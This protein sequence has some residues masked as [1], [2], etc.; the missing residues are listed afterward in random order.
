M[1]LAKEVFILRF[2]NFILL[3]TIW[4]AECCKQFWCYSFVVF[5]FQ[6]EDHDRYKVVSVVDG[7]WKLEKFTECHRAMVFCVVSVDGCF[8]RKENVR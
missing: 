2:G 6:R 3:M 4:Q 8:Q 1:A 7:S 5:S